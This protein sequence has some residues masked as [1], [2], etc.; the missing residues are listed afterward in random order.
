M[1]ANIG[2]T[3]RPFG[4][5]VNQQGGIVRG[6]EFSVKAK[7]TRSTDIFAS[8]TVTNSLQRTPQV[9]GIRI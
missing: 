5:Y 3:S 1:V 9:T 2:S 6:G 7:A 8:Y 4:G